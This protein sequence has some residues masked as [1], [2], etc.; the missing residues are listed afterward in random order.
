[1]GFGEDFLNA[2]HAIQPHVQRNLGDD[3]QHLAPIGRGIA[4]FTDYMLP[5]D[6]SGGKIKKKKTKKSS[7]ADSVANHGFWKAIDEALAR[8][9]YGPQQKTSAHLEHKMQGPAIPDALVARGIGQP[10][11]A[12]PPVNPLY[13]IAQQLM[14]APP[15]VDTSS[16]QFLRGKQK[17]I[18]SALMGARHPWDQAIVDTRANLKDALAGID[19]A[20]AGIDPVMQGTARGAEALAQSD[21][22]NIDASRDAALLKQRQDA[23]ATAHALGIG[24]DAAQQAGAAAAVATHADAAGN[25]GDIE[26]RTDAAKG[27]AS[28]IA[29]ASKLQS[30]ETKSALTRDAQR[31]VNRLRGQRASN[32]Q[33]ARGS[34]EQQIAEFIQQQVADNQDLAFKRTQLGVGLMGQAQQNDLA[35]QNAADDRAYRNQQQ[36]IAEQQARDSFINGLIGRMGQQIKV[37]VD[38][39]GDGAFDTDK[40]GRPIYQYAPA[41]PGSAAW[42]VASQRLP[43]AVAT[44][45]TGYAPSP[46]SNSSLTDV[47]KWFSQ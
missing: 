46:T 25:L 38:S 22:A 39:N 42:A 10:K 2:I 34:V 35:Q 45:I 4:D 28:T 30:Q 15:G 43:S 31:E 1:M 18:N 47:W 24:E 3:A 36:R 17:Q 12:A 19:S 37:P 44:A 16:K 29:Q 21:R 32:M 20:T 7:K 40:S 11:S 14:Q 41:L 6:Q 23:A 27:L 9:I 26:R 5:G 8:G 33:Q 13:Q